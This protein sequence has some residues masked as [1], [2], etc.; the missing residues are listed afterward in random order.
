MKIIIFAGGELEYTE[1]YR[2]L[3]LDSDFIICCDSGSNH[4]HN[5]DIV[6]NLIVGD[7]DSIDGKVLAEFSKLNVEFH[8]F[9]KAKDATDLELA[10]EA[11]KQHSPHEIT[12]LGGFGG[13]VDHLFG[14]VNVLVAATLSGINISMLDLHTKITVIQNTA[15]IAKEDYEYISLIPLAEGTRITACGLEYPLNKDILGLWTTLGISNKFCSD[16]AAITLESGLLLAVCTKS[17]P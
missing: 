3:A 10:V 16:I 17:C 14:N 5:L 2:R 9:P 4:A 1:F 11:A 15:E 13:R 7:L 6:P 12:I 8:I